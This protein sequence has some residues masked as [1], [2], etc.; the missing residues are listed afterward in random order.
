MDA[1]VG[2]AVEGADRAR[3]LALEGAQIAHVL[4]EAGDAEALVVVEQFV[5]DRTAARQAVGRQGHAQPRRLVGRH[6]DRR[7]ALYLI[8]DTHLVEAL[9]DRAGGLRLDAGV[10]RHHRRGRHL[11]GEIDECQ[12]DRGPGAHE[13][14]QATVRQRPQISDQIAHTGARFLPVETRT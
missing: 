7:F 11:H 12:Q 1:G 4:L 3:Q 14:D 10:E 6:Q 13:G 2:D 8:G 9:Q 5:A